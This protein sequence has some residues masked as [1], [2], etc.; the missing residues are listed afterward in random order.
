MYQ[1]RHLKEYP[2]VSRMQYEEPPV[3][4]VHPKKLS[5]VHN[6][7]A[8]KSKTNDAHL[9]RTLAM[10]SPKRVQI[11][12]ALHQDSIEFKIMTGLKNSL[13]ASEL[14]IDNHLLPVEE[15]KRIIGYETKHLLDNVEPMLRE[16]IITK[17]GKNVNLQK[18]MDII[19]LFSLLPL[20]KITEPNAS[21]DIYFVLTSGTRGRFS[22]E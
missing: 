11:L 17:D 9:E 15:Y 19:D 2:D 4:K 3:V 8:N 7:I 10:T 22:T 6:A 18:L 5:F 13:F 1:S 16:E 12:Q 21:S 20:K 14:L